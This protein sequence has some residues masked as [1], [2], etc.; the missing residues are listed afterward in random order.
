MTKGR[1]NNCHKKGKRSVKIFYNQKTFQFKF[2]LVNAFGQTAIVER[3]QQAS[4]SE[5]SLLSF[6]KSFLKFHQQFNTFR[7]YIWP[8]RLVSLSVPPEFNSFAKMIDLR[9]YWTLQSSSAGGVVWYSAPSNET[10]TSL[11]KLYQTFACR[12]VRSQLNE[13]QNTRCVEKN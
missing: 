8:A 12:L 2:L 4:P 7:V 13:K 1:E 3:S 5:I 10:N 6:R 11:F 9:E